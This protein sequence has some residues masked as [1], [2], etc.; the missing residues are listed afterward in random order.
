MKIKGLTESDLYIHIDT[1]SFYDGTNSP[2]FPIAPL[3]RTNKKTGDWSRKLTGTSG[4]PL[5]FQ[6]FGITNL[7]DMSDILSLVVGNPGSTNIIGGTNF[8]ECTQTTTNGITETTC[9]TNIVGG[10]TNILINAFA[11]A[12]IPPLVSDA[13]VF[14]FNKKAKL[15]LPP[16][17]P[18]PKASGNMQLKYV[19]PTGQSFL[20]FQASGLS[21]GQGYM[22]WLNDAGTN[23]NAGNFDVPKGG[24]GAFVHYRRDT[25]QGDPLPA[26]AASTA[27]L[28]DR[29]F[30]IRDPTGGVHLFGVLP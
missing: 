14:S 8:I 2:V 6:V 13:S 19:G 29:V 24:G 18:S 12:P 22:L 15:L 5:E 10:A 16:I 11:W 30:T 27:V 25:K 26:Q 3:N 4:A 1:N 20:D 28:T 23:F 21:K 7:S 17:P 9:F